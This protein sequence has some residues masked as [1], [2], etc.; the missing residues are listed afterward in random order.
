MLRGLAMLLLVLCSTP[1]LA[2]KLSF[3][4]RLYPPLKAVFDSGRDDLIQFNNK[5]PSYVTDLIVVR[6]QSVR[7]WTEAMIIIARSPSAKVSTAAEWKAELE[8]QALK[9][10][11]SRFATIGQDENSITFER[12]STG[13]RSGYPATAMYRIVQGQKS[14]FLLGVM[15]KDGITPDARRA[16]LALFASARLE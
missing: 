10:C 2:E 3:D 7:N 15:S 14:M 6:G 16:W 12:N 9:Q 5:N 13:C 4:H 1:A 8:G 11:P